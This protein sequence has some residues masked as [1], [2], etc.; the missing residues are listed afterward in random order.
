MWEKRYEVDQ[1]RVMQLCKARNLQR[2]CGSRE[3]IL[4]I[5]SAWDSKVGLLK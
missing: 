4:I 2:I 3:R 5:C 1:S